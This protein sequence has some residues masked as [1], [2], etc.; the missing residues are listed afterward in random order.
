MIISCPVPEL[1]FNCCLV[2]WEMKWYDDELNRVGPLPLFPSL[3]L[4][5][6]MEFCPQPHNS[7]RRERKEPA[8]PVLAAV[9]D[10]NLVLYQQSP[11]MDVA[12]QSTNRYNCFTY[13]Y[14]LAGA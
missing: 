2:E 9:Q 10:K 1:V 7:R 5:S 13:Y 12:M 11:I 14:Y 4:P 8:K 6:S 3:S